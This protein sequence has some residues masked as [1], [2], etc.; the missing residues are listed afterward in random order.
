MLQT[1]LFQKTSYFNSTF[2]YPAT[3]NANNP[4]YTMSA[5]ANFTMLLDNTLY[6]AWFIAEN[7]YPINPDLMANS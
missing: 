6:D 5:I 7:S 1:S 3:I 4:N 2:V